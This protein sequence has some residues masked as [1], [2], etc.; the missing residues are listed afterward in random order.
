MPLFEVDPKSR[1]VTEVTASTFPELKLWERQDLEAWVTSAPALAGGDFA[2]VTSEFDRFDRTSERLDVLGITAIEPGRGRLVVVELKRDGTSTTVD[3]QAIKYAAYVA[4]AQFDDVVEMHARHHD[5]S[6]DESRAF[7]LELLGGSEDEL[8][9]IDDTPRIVL[10]AG[11][12]RPEVTTTVLWLVDNFEMDVR[13]VRLQPFAVG[14]RVL[15]HSETI[16]PLP[17]AEQYRLGVLR[18]RKET[19][20]EHRERAR[21]GRLIPR[22]LEAEALEIGQVLY[23]RRDAVPTGGPPWTEES[24]M[25]RAKLITA[26]GNRNLEWSDPETGELSLASPSLL[27]AIILHKLGLRRGDITSEG[28]NGMNYWTIEGETSLRD[29]AADSGILEGRGSGRRID[30]EA[31]RQLCKAIPQ[32]RWTTYGDLAAAIG[33]PGAAQ[34]VAGVIATDP[35]IPNAHRV[36]RSTGQISP[37]WT[38]AEGGPEIARQRL[39]EEGV[40]FGDGDVAPLALRWTPPSI[41]S[42][43]PA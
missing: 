6:L 16:I 42:A 34:S 25:Y 43:S 32:G 10:V 11:D 19:E 40:T 12:F 30:R 8:P 17:E 21:A 9:V 2:V 28:I 5:L 20:R 36:L 4:A 29:L 27:A 13:C 39:A 22:L 38:G 35:A 14:E 31:L 37:G 24:P 26:D 23:F 7:L 33:V 18:K 41:D 1:E 15:V 3:L